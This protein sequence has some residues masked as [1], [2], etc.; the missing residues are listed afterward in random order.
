MALPDAS[1]RAAAT[2]ALYLIFRIEADYYAIAA[3]EIEIVLKQQSL[4]KLPGA[5]AWVAGLLTIDDQIV[6]VID[7]YQRILGRPASPQSSTRLVVVQYDKDKLLGLLLEKVNTF[8]RLNLYGW[9][10][11][12]IQL[13][14]TDFLASVQQ[15][16]TLG[17]VQNIE[18]ALLLPEDVHQIL[19][20]STS[21]SYAPALTQ[22]A[23]TTP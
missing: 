17:L 5:P 7:L 16:A 9:M 21:P 1:S 4:K 10:D 13:Y 6:P 18:L 3:S 14:N 12:T 22:Q 15:H 11:A 19:F 2:T 23:K 8:E 20:Q